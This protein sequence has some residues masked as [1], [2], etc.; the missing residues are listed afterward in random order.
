MLGPSAI[1]SKVKYAFTTREG[2]LAMIQTK[3]TE[4]MA[5]NKA[6]GEAV[7]SNVDLDPTPP[8]QRKWGFWY[9]FPDMLVLEIRYQA[10][11][12]QKRF[13]ISD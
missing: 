5:Q 7:L 13:K 8:S 6:S 4:K 2:F 11:R 12:L 10:F 3:E 9:V 1:G